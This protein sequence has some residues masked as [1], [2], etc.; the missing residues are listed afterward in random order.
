MTMPLPIQQE[1]P[2]IAQEP[3]I[4]SGRIWVKGG[5]IAGTGFVFKAPYGVYMNATVLLA[6]ASA[7]RQILRFQLGPLSNTGFR[8]LDRSKLTRY[9]EAFDKLAEQHGIDWSA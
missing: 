3:R 5:S 4:W 8:T 7:T 9:D 2:T 6:R 1:R